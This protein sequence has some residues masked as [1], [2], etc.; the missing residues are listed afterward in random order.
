MGVVRLAIRVFFMRGLPDAVTRVRHMPSRDARMREL[1]PNSIRI[2]TRETKNPDSTITMNW[3]GGNG[4]YYSAP[5]G[6]Q[7][8][9]R[10]LLEFV[11]PDI[12]W[13]TSRSRLDHARRTA[14]HCSYCF[15]GLPGLPVTVGMAF[16]RWDSRMLSQYIQLTLNGVETVI[17]FFH[18]RRIPSHRFH[19]GC[20]TEQCGC[21]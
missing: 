10:Q 18:F 20:Q 17:E 1:C 16:V 8:L 6:R 4:E 9:Q 2:Q 3:R 21:D 13:P 7:G 11:L 12:H 14:A 19:D 5:H 15:R